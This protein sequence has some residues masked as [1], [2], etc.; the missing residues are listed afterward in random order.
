MPRQTNRSSSALVRNLGLS[1]GEGFS[2]IASGPVQPVIQ[3]GDLSEFSTEHFPVRSVA[4]TLVTSADATAGSVAIFKITSLG[5]SGIVI[6]DLHLETIQLGSGPVFANI[7]EGAWIIVN[8][9]DIPGV[10]RYP[11]GNPETPVA[12]ASFGSVSARSQVVTGVRASPGGGPFLPPNFQLQPGMQWFVPPGFDLALQINSQGS[13]GSVVLG[14]V[15]MGFREIAGTG[16]GG[17]VVG[18]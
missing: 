12:L 11:F 16:S 13:P 1:G 5:E 2:Q 17:F 15:E 7:P 14:S 8:T 6:E 10:S 3:I 9:R 4:A 18:Q